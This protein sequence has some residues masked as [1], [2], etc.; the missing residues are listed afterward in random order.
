VPAIPRRSGGAPLAAPPRRVR[1]LPSQMLTRAWNEQ[2]Y[3]SGLARAGSSRELELICECERQPCPRRIRLDV[4]RYELVRQFPTRFLL[5][6]G[7]ETADDERVVDQQT[8]YV[9]VEKT[10]PS[11]LTAIRLDPRRP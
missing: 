3:R 11:A 6:P 9:V 2:S 7:H 8:G 1:S 10:G 4:E 5:R